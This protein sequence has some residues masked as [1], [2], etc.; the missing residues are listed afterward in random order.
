LLICSLEGEL[1]LVLHLKIAG[2]LVYALPDGRRL[3]GGHPYPLPG[4]DLPETSTRFVL[5][6]DGGTLY[7]NDQRRFAWLRLLPAMEVK[8]FVA[9][10]R[11]GPDPLDADFTPEV[12]AAR[13]QARRG[14]PIKAALLDQT[15]IAGL[16]NIYADEALHGARL[17]PLTRAGALST[18]EVR[19]LHESIGRVLAVAVP[20]GGAVVKVGRAIAEPESG[21]DFLRAHGRAGE[22]CPACADRLA[23]AGQDGEPPPIIRAVLAGRSTYF[24]PV[25][26]PAPADVI[27]VSDSERPGAEQ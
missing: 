1:A 6:L 16:G 14:R 9:T 26:Q 3:V 10:Q 15:C 4:V 20:V 11:F 25:C 18:E 13:L 17:H 7:V 12:L 22:P 2:Q 23:R 19:R 27:P 24:C 5:E 8:T 21:R